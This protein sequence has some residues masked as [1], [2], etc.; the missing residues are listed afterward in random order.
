MVKEM[1]VNKCFSLCDLD[2]ALEHKN[3]KVEKQPIGDE[4]N[5]VRRFALNGKSYKIIWYINTCYLEH[6]D[7]LVKFKK[8]IQKNTWPNRSKMNLQFYNDN[9]DVCCIISIEKM[10]E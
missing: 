9:N 7:I 8:V 2:K 1:C 3:I 5:R 4:L 6:N 10:N